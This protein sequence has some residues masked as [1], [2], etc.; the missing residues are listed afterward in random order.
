MG[1]ANIFEY[2][3]ILFNLIWEREGDI[4]R[5]QRTTHFREKDIAEIERTTRLAILEGFERHL[6]KKE[7]FYE[8]NVD[9][10]LFDLIYEKKLANNGDYS[11]LIERNL[12]DLN[13]NNRRKFQLKYL[14]Y[15]MDLVDNIIESG[16]IE[17]WEYLLPTQD[18]ILSF[19]DSIW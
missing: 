1:F 14:Y 2:K 7:R 17:N 6:D 18:S 19:F 5:H 13:R 4:R 12:E 8:L 9:W 3:K 16:D 15:V 11:V 10:R